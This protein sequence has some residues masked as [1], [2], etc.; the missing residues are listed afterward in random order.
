MGSQTLPH[1]PFLWKQLGGK[2]VFKSFLLV[3][4]SSCFVCLVLSCLVFWKYRKISWMHFL[5]FAFEIW[6]ILAILCGSQSH[7]QY[8]KNLTLRSCF[9]CPFF[10][11]TDIKVF[12]CLDNESIRSDINCAFEHLGKQPD[13]LCFQVWLLSLLFRSGCRVLN[14]QKTVP[15]S[16]QITLS[17][18]WK[19]TSLL[20]FSGELLVLNHFLFE[21][22]L[23]CLNLGC[24]NIH[25][26]FLK[27]RQSLSSVIFTVNILF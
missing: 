27:L 16:K 15:Q 21:F 9:I 20:S 22:K 4:S 14:R 10:L 24:V 7:I 3:F 25:I 13:T 12:L 6:A 11:L 23:F 8:L 1:L 26:F 2:W 19:N 17:L 5:H 18:S